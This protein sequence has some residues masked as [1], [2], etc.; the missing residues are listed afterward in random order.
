MQKN[1]IV[2]T[3]LAFA[4]LPFSTVFAA[5]NS[6]LAPT[7]YTPSTYT[8]PQYDPFD[9]QYTNPINIP[10][11]E[12]D[13]APNAD[14]LIY[15]TQT[16]SGLPANN[17]GTTETEFIFDASPSTDVETGPSRLEVR[18]D[19]ENDGKI[20]RFFSLT[21][22]VRHRYKKAGTYEV[23]LEVLDKGGNVSSVIKTVTVVNNTAPTAFFRYSPSSGTP[24]TTF[25]F[26]TTASTDDQYLNNSLQ[27]R[28]DWNG[29]GIW[30]TKFQSKTQWNHQ[31]GKAGTFPVIMEVRD[32]EGKKDQTHATIV[33]KNNTAPHAEFTIKAMRGAYGTTYEFDASKSG[34][35]ETS[36]T[37]LL[38]RWDFN[39]HGPDD[40]IYNTST[41][42]NDHYSGTYAMPGK[43]V[44]RLEVTDA[45][46]AK[47]YSYAM[48]EVMDDDVV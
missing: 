44:V 6:M 21:R 24:K 22:S 26:Q 47:D 18:W 2:A 31:F 3:I 23:K 15:N 20:D 19:F 8:A 48:I 12:V 1:R 35:Q 7:N 39:Y 30:D 34:D 32:P 36:H 38:Y 42:S 5:Y 41:N 16:T 10:E 29:D 45:D 33:I 13:T 14:F 28:F 43:K 46:G 9:P 40:I 25:N 37:R 27:Y 17:S 11:V 4:L